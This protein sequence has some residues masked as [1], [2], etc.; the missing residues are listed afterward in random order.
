MY[1]RDI[2]IMKFRA[3]F[4]CT[5]YMIWKKKTPKI[6]RQHKDQ[7]EILIFEEEKKKVFA[8]CIHKNNREKNHQ[9]DYDFF[10]T[11]EIHS[12]VLADIWM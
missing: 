4:G 8:T 2:F 1:D 9:V 6:G 3:M 7:W 12:I 10:A 5:V 11:I